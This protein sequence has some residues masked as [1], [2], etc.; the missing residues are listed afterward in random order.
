MAALL[1]SLEEARK[2]Q[3]ALANRTTA[4]SV[5]WACGAEEEALAAEVLDAQ[6][7]ATLG[8]LREACS[9][10]ALAGLVYDTLVGIF[11]EHSIYGSAQEAETASQR[12]LRTRLAFEQAVADGEVEVEETAMFVV[13]RAQAWLDST[14]D[15]ADEDLLRELEELE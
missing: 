13:H 4:A 11:Q 8:A 3:P 5:M 14:V 9:H 15:T 2:Q 12:V 7:K 6:P 1:S 10:V